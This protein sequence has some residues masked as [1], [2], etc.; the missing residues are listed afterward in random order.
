[1][2]ILETAEP[3]I[4]ICTRDV[5]PTA[6][7]YREVLG[8]RQVSEDKYAA[9]FRAGGVNLRVSLVPDFI[10]TGHTTL[11]FHVDDL[12]V[13]AKALRDNGVV[14]HR[15]QGLALDESGIFNL[16]GGLGQVIWFADPQGNLLSVTNV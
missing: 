16:P 4:L 9:V 2:G 6:A 1:M 8:L 7:F 5:P 12:A 13:T 14:F 3:I 10:P 15:P 11:G